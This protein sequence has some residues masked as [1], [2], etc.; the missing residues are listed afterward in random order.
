MLSTHTPAR[1]VPPATSGMSADGFAS[2]LIVVLDG[3]TA[4]APLRS[5][6]PSRREQRPCQV[7]SFYAPTLPIAGCAG[8]WEQLSAQAA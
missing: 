4:T 3:A 2:A 5:S 6:E 8:V 7:R 1:V